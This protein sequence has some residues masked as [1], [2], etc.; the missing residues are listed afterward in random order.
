[1]STRRRR[2]FHL[3]RKKY[4]MEA[5]TVHDETTR[6]AR[7]EHTCCECKAAI[8]PGDTYVRHSGLWDSRWMSYKWCMGCQEKYEAAREEQPDFTFCYT[9]LHEA[10]K[11]DEYQPYVR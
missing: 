1:M 3:Q 6:T 8:E 7:K 4:D 11:G 10:L 2:T 9:Q 5:P